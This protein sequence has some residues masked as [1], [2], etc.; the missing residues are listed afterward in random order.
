[1]LNKADSIRQNVYERRIVIT[2]VIK[3]VFIE[4]RASEIPEADK[5]DDIV[6]DEMDSI[7]AGSWADDERD[8]DYSSSDFGTEGFDDNNNGNDGDDDDDGFKRYTI[9]A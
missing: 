4:I 9:I 5:S 8:I 3:D 1:M 6:R 2:F 7:A